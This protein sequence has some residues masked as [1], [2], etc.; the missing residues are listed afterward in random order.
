MKIDERLGRGLVGG[1]GGSDNAVVTQGNQLIEGSYDINLSE[2]R[3]LWLALTKV[4]SKNPRPSA[5]IVLTV[6]EFSSM[7]GLDLGNSMNQL[8]SISESLGT[9]PIHTYEYNE[10]KDRLDKVIRFWFSSIRYGVNNTADITLK[11]S[12]DV[13]PFL[14]E[15]KNEFTQMNIV[16]MAKLDTSFSFRLF[17]WLSRYRKL[18]KYKN[19][20]TGVISTQKISVDWMKDRAGLTGKYTD[21][22]NFRVRVIEPAIEAINRTTDLSV[23]YETVFEGKKVTDLI[24]H[25]I[26]E[27]EKGYLRVKPEPPKLPRRP[28]VLKGSHAE[29]EWAKACLDKLREYQAQ[30]TNYDEKEKISLLYLRKQINYYTILGNK[31]AV[32]FIEKE[33]KNRKNK[34]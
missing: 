13:S 12:E 32:D 15:L 28:R 19:D 7:Y 18:D 9:K 27:G 8:K 25:F 16:S 11:F 23:R 34:K 5:E 17:S 30:L 6:A 24:F 4:D 33:I 22:K 1:K 14:Y 3:L 10:K 20:K 31:D 26:I 21:F 29:G 2:I